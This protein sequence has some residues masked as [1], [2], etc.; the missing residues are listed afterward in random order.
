MNYY[1]DFSA[2]VA[3]LSSKTEQHIRTYICN[4]LFWW[5]LINERKRVK[6]TT[7]IPRPLFHTIL[8]FTVS[9]IRMNEYGQQKDGFV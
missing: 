7:M 8:W 2:S 4:T 1:T 3:S 5:P 9:T 6:F